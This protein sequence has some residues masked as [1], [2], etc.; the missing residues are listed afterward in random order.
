MLSQSEL[1]YIHNY[2]WN[3]GT[4]TYHSHTCSIDTVV[5][6]EDSLLLCQLYCYL[7]TPLMGLMNS[8]QYG[9]EDIDAEQGG[10]GRVRCVCLPSV[11]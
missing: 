9:Y 10:K 4:A 11:F 1:I 2:V 5:A 3:P 7:C 6:T 8:C